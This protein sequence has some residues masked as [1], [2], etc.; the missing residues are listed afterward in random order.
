MKLTL[1]LSICKHLLIE[2]QKT[3]L[4]PANPRCKQLFFWKGDQGKWGSNVVASK[5]F[6]VHFKA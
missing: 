1:K 6:I 3:S 4:H 5:I 2:Q